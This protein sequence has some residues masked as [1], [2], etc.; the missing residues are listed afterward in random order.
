MSYDVLTQNGKGKINGY[1]WARIVN[2]IHLHVKWCKI[3]QSE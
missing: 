1:H 2:N 3:V